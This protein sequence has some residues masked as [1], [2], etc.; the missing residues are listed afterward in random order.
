MAK[1]LRSRS[2]LPGVASAI[3]ELLGVIGRLW[4]PRVALCDFVDTNCSSVVTAANELPSKFNAALDAYLSVADELKPHGEVITFASEAGTPC[5]VS[6]IVAEYAYEK[7]VGYAQREFE[8]PTPAFDPDMSWTAE[9]VAYEQ[10]RSSM[11]WHPL[12][13]SDGV[14]LRDWMA[15][16]E[17]VDATTIN[18]LKAGVSLQCSRATA[19]RESRAREAAR[20]AR[21][22][23]SH[24][25]QLR[26]A[27]E[28]S[29][30]GERLA[31]ERR[32]IDEERSR[33]I[34]EPPPCAHS[35]DFHS[36]RWYGT[37]YNFSKAQAAC[38]RVLW[39][40][41]ERRVPEVAAATILKLG[42]IAGDRLD[43]VFGTR[44]RTSPAWKTLIVP[45]TTK[46]TYRLNDPDAVR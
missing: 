31:V 16:Y 43:H 14:S 13:Q 26:I 45:G 29:A 33:T 5:E 37:E 9:T 20:N 27:A 44:H 25:E 35:D 22:A 18:V 40:H 36:V 15:R 6:L 7:V 21:Q 42:D 17:P 30:E 19:A 34:N 41:W 38:V 3:R 24:R 46:G 2:K 23:R 8:R 28:Q 12:P 32:L 39:E 10:R 4:A 1:T 11:D